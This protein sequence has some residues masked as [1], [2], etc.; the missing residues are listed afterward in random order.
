MSITPVKRSFK[1]ALNSS[2]VDS[3]V[4]KQFNATFYVDFL[5]VIRDPE[6][7]KKQFKMSFVFQCPYALATTNT[8]SLTAGS[9]Y[10][11]HIDMGKAQYIGMANFVKPPSGVV[12]VDAF[13][14]GTAVYTRFNS[15]YTD[16]CPVFIDNLLS[17]NQIT[18]QLYDFQTNTVF[19]TANDTT[20]NNATKYICILQF[21]EL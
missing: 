21:D 7:L 13:M 16:N 3:F 19:N 20:I 1:Y 8:I 17:V 6:L 5:K 2:D 12:T 9:T 4:G 14:D 15:L 18:L 10:G 11:L